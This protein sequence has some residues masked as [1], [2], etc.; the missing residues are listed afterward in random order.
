MD[1]HLDKIYAMAWCP[2]SQH[3]V[4]AAQDGKLLVYDAYS[5]C[6]THR[7]E[8]ENRWVMACA[9]SPQPGPSL[10][11]TV[12]CS[13]HRT[14][15]VVASGGLDN[16]VSIYVLNDDEGLGTLKKQMTGHDGYVGGIQFIDNSKLVRCDFSL[17]SCML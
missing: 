2:D 11:V 8:L 6:K 1:G 10:P 9:Y 3:I 17:H 14:T 7:V 12:C 5:G 13:S 15:G 16:A 4:T